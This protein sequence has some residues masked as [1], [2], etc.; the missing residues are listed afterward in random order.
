MKN[1]CRGIFIFDAIG[2]V[3]TPGVHF[4][5]ARS[6]SPVRASFKG[7][8]MRKIQAAALVVVLLSGCATIIYENG[9]YRHEPVRVINPCTQGACSVPQT[10]CGFNASRSAPAPG[11]SGR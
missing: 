8:S 6:I 7:V 9:E 10:S 1:G 11:C 2:S 4:P 3:L 5:A